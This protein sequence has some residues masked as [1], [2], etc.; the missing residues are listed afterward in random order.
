[1]SPN[2]LSVQKQRLSFPY[3]YFAVKRLLR[4]LDLVQQPFLHTKQLN[5]FL[6]FVSTFNSSIKTDRVKTTDTYQ[7]IDNAGKP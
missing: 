4:S 2:Y 3:N 5:L 7:R 6:S 1:M